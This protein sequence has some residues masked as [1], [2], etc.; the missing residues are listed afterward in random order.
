MDVLLSLGNVSLA[1]GGVSN[2]RT[3]PGCFFH[4]YRGCMDSHEDAN[5][6][7]NRQG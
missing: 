3:L 4:L 7:V 2:A 6:K 5:V 1:V